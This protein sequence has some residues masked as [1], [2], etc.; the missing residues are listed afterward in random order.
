[1]TPP[2]EN[3]GDSQLS[4]FKKRLEEVYQQDFLDQYMNSLRQRYRVEINEAVYKK[5]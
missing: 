2:H 1:M 3:K 5:L 4:D